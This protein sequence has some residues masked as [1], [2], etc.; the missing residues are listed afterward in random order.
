[1]KI[2]V[3]SEEDLASQ[4]IKQQ[5]LIQY[6]FKENGIFEDNTIYSYKNKVNLITIKGKLI[7]S[8]YLS[9]YF[10]PELFIYASRHK[11]ESQM[12]SLLTHSTGNWGSGNLFGGQP[13]SVSYSSPEAVRIA[14]LELLYQKKVLNLSDFDVTMEVTHHGPSELK[15]PLVF[16]ELGSSEEYWTHKEGALAV[17]RAIMKVV[18]NKLTFTN[19]IGFGGTHYCSNFNKILEKNEDIA[20]GHIIPKYVIDQVGSELILLAFEKSKAKFA[21]IDHKGTNSAQ[22]QKIKEILEKKSIQLKRIKELT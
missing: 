17:A 4:T 13:R 6:E 8:D 2:I 22:K 21:V 10:T 7:E 5:L 12:P 9:D 15:N 18:D 3:T 20:I 14:Y 1:M 19:I 11:A 16:I